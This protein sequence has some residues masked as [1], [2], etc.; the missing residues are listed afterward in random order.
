MYVLQG[1]KMPYDRSV[2]MFDEPHAPV[3]LDQMASAKTINKGKFLSPAH[4]ESYLLQMQTIKS[5]S[6]VKA[7]LE[8]GPGEGFAAKNL[9]EL[10]FRYDTLDFEDAHQPTIKADFGSLDPAVIG[11]R[12]DLTCAF[13]VLEHFPYR[14]FTR[15]LGTLSALS[16]KYVFIS[17]PFSCKGFSL[18]LNFQ[19][20]QQNRRFRSFD[21]YIPTNLP[22]RKYREEYM[23]EFPW[24]VH[25]WEVGRKGYPLKKVLHDVESCGLDVVQRFHSPNAFHYFILCT[26]RPG[27]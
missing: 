7:I 5:L 22:N 2:K 18:K 11:Q 14:D 1:P 9:R 15:H 25:F 8:V 6:G 23:R 16:R 10:G 24:A 19:S 17:L 26:K 21:F 27:G 20:G 12:Y 4:A 13:Q 3:V